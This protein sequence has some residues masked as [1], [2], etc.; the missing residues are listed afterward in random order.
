MLVPYIPIMLYYRAHAEHSGSWWELADLAEGGGTFLQHILNYY[1]PG[2][3]NGHY[4][5]TYTEKL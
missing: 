5:L 4:V 2:A 1:Q 3:A